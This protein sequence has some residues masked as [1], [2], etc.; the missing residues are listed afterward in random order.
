MIAFFLRHI[1]LM[2]A[3][4]PT[5]FLPAC[6]DFFCLMLKLVYLYLP[7]L[8][9]RSFLAAWLLF[10]RLIH[11]SFI[12]FPSSSIIN[13]SELSR[14]C[15][16]LLLLRHTFIHH[17]HHSHSHHSNICLIKCPN[18]L[19]GGLS[20][21]KKMAWIYPFLAIGPGLLLQNVSLILIY[22]LPS[23][24]HRWRQKKS[25]CLTKETF[26]ISSRCK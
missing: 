3:A 10:V 5:L 19:C 7:V 16:F 15:V 13:L 12:F 6:L 11:L 8:S 2:F 1:K 25:Q 9:S 24:L 23:N 26:F 21:T 22:F 20:R 4:S 14:R 18:P 17:R